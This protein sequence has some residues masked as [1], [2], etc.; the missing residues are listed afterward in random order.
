MSIGRFF[1]F[2]FISLLPA[3]I[4]HLLYIFFLLHFKL[5]FLGSRSHL[6]QPSGGGGEREDAWCATVCG[7]R[8][9]IRDFGLDHCRPF[10][11][12]Q[13]N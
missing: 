2:S 5:I 13:K 8:A 12:F 10:V 3:I 9:I 7:W 11:I 1:I 6:I 4:F